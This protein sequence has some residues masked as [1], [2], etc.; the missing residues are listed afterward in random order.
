M[1]DEIVQFADSVCGFYFRAIFLPRAGMIV[2]QHVHDYD[3]PTYVGSGAARLYVDGKPAGDYE[4]GSAVPIYKGHRHAWESL[5]PDTRLAC[6]HNV[7]SAL[8]IKRKGL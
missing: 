3:H 2:A 7:D 8:S 1:S 5:K 6:I 4:A